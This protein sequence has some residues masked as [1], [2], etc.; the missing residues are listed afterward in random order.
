LFEFL[1]LANIK[2]FLAEIVFCCFK[3][4]FSNSYSFV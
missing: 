1:F 4:E 2:F 3:T